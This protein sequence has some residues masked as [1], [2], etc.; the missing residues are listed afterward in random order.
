MLWI[1]A[2]LRTGVDTDASMCVADV[3]MCVGSTDASMCVAV[4]MPVC[5][6]QY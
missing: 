5:V 2:S 6:W 1:L 3:R 4:L